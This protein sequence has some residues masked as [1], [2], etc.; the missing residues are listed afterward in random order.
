MFVTVLTKSNFIEKVN[1]KLGRQPNE[2]TNHYRSM[3]AFYS[4]LDKNLHRGT[5]LFI[6][7][8]H[9]QGLAVSSVTQ[10]AVNFGI[11]GDTTAGVIQR[12]PKYTSLH[13]ASSIVLSIG[14]NDLQRRSNQAIVDNIRTILDFIPA[15][16][17]TVLCA[18]HLVDGNALGNHSLNPRIKQINT[19]L[20]KISQEYPNVAFL[21]ISNFLSSNGEL[22]AKY[23]EGDGIHL[24]REG[25]EI[26]I[27]HLMRALPKKTDALN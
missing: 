1:V 20:K 21:N 7:D 15:D 22:A 24:N 16:T 3:Q 11:G 6:G 25:Y 9:I 13:L 14:F 5:T 8:S 27:H 10:Y 26:W 12:L 18:I 23:H 19:M 17:N 2:I 4:R